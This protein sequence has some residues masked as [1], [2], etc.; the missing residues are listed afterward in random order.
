MPVLILVFIGL[1]IFALTEENYPGL[2]G[3]ILAVLAIGVYL[4]L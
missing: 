4:A 2:V 3:L 1:I